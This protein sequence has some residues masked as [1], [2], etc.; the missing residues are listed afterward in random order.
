MR[1]LLF[2]A[3]MATTACSV[4]AQ[5]ARPR[6][7]A[8]PIEV[9]HKHDFEQTHRGDWFAIEAFSPSGVSPLSDTVA[10]PAP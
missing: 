5:E 6:T 2:A 4:L 10:A 9:D 1:T 8:N 7:G 3:I